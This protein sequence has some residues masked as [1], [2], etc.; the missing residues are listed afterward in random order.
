[1]VHRSHFPPVD[2]PEMPLTDFVLERALD[3]PDRPAIVN[4]ETG[5][6]LTYGALVASVGDWAATLA[7]R[8]VG[9][10]TVCAIYGPNSPEYAVVFYAIA[11]V[12][13]IITTI[14]P[15]YTVSE[16][17]HQLRDSGAHVLVAA[18][19]LMHTAMQA[20][21]LAG[22]TETI[23][24][25]PLAEVASASTANRQAGAPSCDIAIDP[26]RDLV[27][28]PYSSGTT[29]LPKGVMLTHYNIVA[30]VCQTDAVERIHPD[31]VL[32]AALPFYHIYAMVVVMNRALHAGATIVTM[33]QFKIHEFLEI[34]QK[35]R[36]SLAYLVPPLV[37]TLATHAEVDHYDL[38]SL[39]E[40]V[41]G[42]APLPDPLARR[43]SER[44]GCTVRQLYG[45]TE[46]G[47]LTHIMPRDRMRRNSVG[48][49]LPNT[50]FRIVDV[51]L[52][53]DVGPEELGEVWIRGPQIMQGYLNNPEATAA[54]L[55][56]DGWLR[57]GD[58]GYV[59]SD[60]YL[61][62]VERAKELM[63]FRGLHY[64][65]DELLLSMVEDIAIRRQAAARVGFQA[66]LL[67]SV[68]EAVVATDMTL[69]VTF[70]NRGSEHL[71][72]YAAEEAIG[73][74][75]DEL[76]L[77]TRDRFKLA[78]DPDMA[79]LRQS[80]RWQGHVLRRRKD[81]SQFWADLVVSAI[82]VDG[83]RSG[84]IAIHRD[85]S[86]LKRSQ[87]LIQDSQEQLR[88]LAS[89]LM[90]IREH[91]RSAISR[92]LHDELGQMLTRL[93]IDLC[94][95]T[96][97]LPRSL[98]TKRSAAMPALID[99]MVAT[100]QHISAQLRPAILDDLGLE[101]AIEWHAKEFA[102]WSGCDCV[103]D[104]DL[105][106]LKGERDRDIAVFRVVQEA[107]TNVAR[108]SKAHHVTV[109]ARIGAADLVVDVEDDGVGIPETRWTSSDSLGLIGMRERADG[110]GGRLAW[111][112]RSPNGTVMTL[113]V[114][115]I[116]G[117]HT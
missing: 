49:S 72:G 5:S 18:P 57:T 29:G 93:K 31:E 23:A 69:R 51:V 44:I 90:S 47:P 34:I 87:Q 40:V 98:R 56:K 113:R 36:V 24:L 17:T 28:L 7:R 38:S 66:L 109:R 3:E 26:R 112:R 64:G 99:K 115:L 104:L 59:D 73:R 91:E 15:L 60:G 43:C 88:N 45:L 20:A 95:L 21:T 35:Y 78:W 100:V 63:K 96:E 10:G 85:I 6:V 81:W 4:G 25:G 71:F 61:Y 65:E 83:A 12:G 76:V 30:N 75:V 54:M 22:V 32:I 62:V 27:A 2:I 16:L 77:P 14:S 52:K 37:R 86:E 103:L 68:Q 50:E 107:L 70:W 116:R 53:R 80:G 82:W 84:F 11:K 101:A 13:G 74:P 1:M 19:Y 106:S 97:R 92:E 102:S 110:L 8:G 89:S 48:L 105:A 58:I 108:H 67:D 79:G 55:D 39:R 42:A 117:S 114:P 46:A 9:K 111:Q 41:S 33:S 94:W